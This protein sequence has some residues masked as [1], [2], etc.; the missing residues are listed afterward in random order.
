MR[1]AQL[2]EI[3]PANG[4]QIQ[5]LFGNTTAGSFSPYASD[6]STSITLDMIDTEYSILDAIFYPWMKDINS[7]WWYKPDAA[8]TEWATPYPM[9]TME[10]QRPRMRYSENAKKGESRKDGTYN[11]Y[12]YKLLGVKPTGYNSFEVNGAGKS[13]LVRQLTLI[14]DMCI[15]DLT[16]DAQGASATSTNLGNRTALFAEPA[17]TNSDSDEDED[18]EPD[19]EAMQKEMDDKYRKE[20]EEMEKEMEENQED[21]EQQENDDMPG[22]DEDE[23]G[24]EDYGDDEDDSDMDYDDEDYG[25]EEDF[26][27]EDYG[28]EDLGDEDWERDLDG[29]GDPSMDGYD[30]PDPNGDLNDFEMD[31][32]AEEGQ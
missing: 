7:P 29:D 20:L 31:K 17:N 23:W 28:Y 27:E 19:W 26:G 24:D 32:Q 16:A 13:S 21:M 1:Q 10:I 12:S 22:E 15:V 5:T 30:E 18:K 3:K 9:A 6:G 8:F 4:E 25:D 2:P 11:Y 14:C